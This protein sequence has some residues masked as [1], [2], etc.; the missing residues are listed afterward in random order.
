MQGQPANRNS[1]RIKII[2]IIIKNDD[3]DDDDDNKS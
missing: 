1:K 2:I 3:N